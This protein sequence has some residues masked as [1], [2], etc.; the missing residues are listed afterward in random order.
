[1]SSGEKWELADTVSHEV[2]QVDVAD[3]R[4]AIVAAAQLDA[5]WSLLTVVGVR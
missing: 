4:R 3:S 1:M 2:V 5:L